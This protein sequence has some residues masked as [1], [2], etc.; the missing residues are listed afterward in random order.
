MK[1]KVQNR[2]DEKYWM[3]DPDESTD[4][5]RKAYIFDTTKPSDMVNFSDDYDSQNH[6]IKLLT[7][8]EIK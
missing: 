6:S 5:R 8:K 7:D 4:D 1:F 3:L 2:G